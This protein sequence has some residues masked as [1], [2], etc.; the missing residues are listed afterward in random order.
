MTWIIGRGG[1]IYYKA[2]WTDATD[3]E[4][5]LTE[6]LDALAR[7]TS[8]PIAPFHAERLAWRSRDMEAFRRQLEIAGPQAVRDFFGPPRGS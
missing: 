6:T 2:A 3:I 4:S 1:V 8:E 7:R 5:A